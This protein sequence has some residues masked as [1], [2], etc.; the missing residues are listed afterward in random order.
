MGLKII[1]SP[2]IIQGNTV[3]L[4][5]KDDKAFLDE[6]KKCGSSHSNNR[7]DMID[8]AIGEKQI[9]EM[10]QKHYAEILNSNKDTRTWY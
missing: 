5:T 10:W 2:G 9:L 3:L 8:N 1:I 7:A 4:V 6:I